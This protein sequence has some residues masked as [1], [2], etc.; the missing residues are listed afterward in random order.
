MSQ[1]K[2]AI[3]SGEI[4][5][6]Q[7]ASLLALSLKKIKP[8]AEILG[9]GGNK[10]K[11]SGVKIIAENPLFGSFGISS[12]I[13][14]IGKYVKFLNLCVS[15]IRKENP[16]LIIFIDNPGFN[17]NLAKK[18][19]DFRKIYYITPK[20]WAHGY[21]RV[22]LIKHLFEAVIVIFPFEKKLF[23]KEGVP[24][25]YFGHPVLDLIDETKHDE[26][27]FEKTGLN[28]RKT[29]VGIFPGS[30]KEEIELILPI[31][32]KAIKLI[33]KNHH[34][35]SIVSCADEAFLPTIKE[36]MDKEKFNCPVWTGSPH[37]MA[38]NSYI[39]LAASGTMNLELALLGTPMI[40]FYRM[41]KLN[42][43]IARIIVQLNCVSPV[44]IICDKKIIEEFIQ[45]INW[46]RFQRVFSQILYSDSEKRKS[47]IEYFKKMREQLGSQNI[48]EKVAQFILQRI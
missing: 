44:N 43:I 47:Q 12:V 20:F 27:F 10:L 23:E 25:F 7:Y 29:I 37:M 8:S 41:G 2:I 46:L 21:Q 1:P 28:K 36:I 5:G 30:R 31:L 16:D 45:N 26:G 18:L 14:N 19:P 22:F 42:Y 17:L 33:Q 9:I 6:D 48:S 13:R 3:V 24:A 4:S 40:V 15:S 34:V 11:Q 32:I 38:R 35:S 39:A